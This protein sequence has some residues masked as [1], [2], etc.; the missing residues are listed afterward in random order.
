MISLFNAIVRR[1][2]V[3]R[4][5][6][7]QRLM[8]HVGLV[9]SPNA[10]VDDGDSVASDD[11]SDGETEAAESSSGTDDVAVDVSHLT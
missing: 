2:H 1:G 9:V 3:P 5:P 10:T 7:I 4:E 11:I 6:A 8:T